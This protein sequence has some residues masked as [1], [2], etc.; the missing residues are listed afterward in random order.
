M[1]AARPFGST[2]PDRIL[3][4]ARSVLLIAYHFPPAVGSSGLQ[5]TLRFAQYLPLFGWQPVVLTVQP[6]AHEVTDPRSLADVPA[7]CEVVRT[8]CLDAGRHLSIGGRYPRI[9]ALPDRWASWSLLGLRPAIRLVRSRRISAVWSTYPIA[10]AHRLAASVARRTAVPWVADFRD[11]MAQ[12]GYPEDP[13][14]WKAFKG[15]EEDAVSSAARL[16]FVA[17]SAQRMYRARYPEVDPERFVLIENGYDES[18][19]AGIDAPSPAQ[20]RHPGTPV[21]LHSGIVYPSERDPRALFTALGM[22]SRE[23]RIRPGDFVLRFRAP[24]HDELLRGLGSAHGVTQYLEIL[25]PLPYRDALAEMAQADALLVLQG[26]N[27]NE[28]IPAKAYEYLRTGKPVLGLADPNGDTGRL[29]AAM[30]VPL[31]TPL[32]S[33]A[34]I[35]QTLPE[36]LS[37]LREGRWPHPQRSKVEHFSRKALTARLAELFDTVTD[38]HRSA[39]VDGR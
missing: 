17:P 2:R 35:A 11:P 3:K 15:I 18:A 39:A 14:R 9:A 34:G 8:P 24:V 4:M 16:V 36:F 13:R 21:I 32:E 27:C 6:T 30:D 37:R 1:L 19:F 23:K 22:L 28:Q 38:E 20:G 10:T 25:P 5:R 7:G 12:E 33:E 26:A 31:V 29:L